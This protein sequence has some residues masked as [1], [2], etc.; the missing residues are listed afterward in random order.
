MA[1]M[2]AERDIM[3]KVGIW[4]GGV[5][6]QPC[7]TVSTLHAL[8]RLSLKQHFHIGVLCPD[9]TSR[10]FALILS[11][12]QF[13]FLACNMKPLIAC[14]AI[15]SARCR[16][17]LWLLYSVLFRANP[18]CSWLWNISQAASCFSTSARKAC[19][20]RSTRGFTRPKWYWRWSI[21][22]RRASSTGAEICGPG[23]GQLRI[24]T[25]RVR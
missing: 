15:S 9:L 4:F 19:F 6:K 14:C 2:Q 8:V 7:R 20:R 22:T 10:S 24:N 12:L 13:E 25:G 5:S 21:C 3:T 18:S 1:Y 23:L 11:E 16:T 17:P